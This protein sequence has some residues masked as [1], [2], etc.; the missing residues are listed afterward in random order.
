MC[1]AVILKNLTLMA[2]VVTVYTVT[3]YAVQALPLKQ[4]QKCLG[5]GKY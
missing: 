5:K 1:E 3:C 4:Q 2:I